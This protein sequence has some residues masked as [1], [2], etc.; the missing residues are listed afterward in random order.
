[1]RETRR[2]T[3]PATVNSSQ[4]RISVGVSFPGQASLLPISFAMIGKATPSAKRT[5]AAIADD[6]LSGLSAMTHNVLGM[7]GGPFRRIVRAHGSIRR[8]A[9]RVN[10]HEPAPCRGSAGHNNAYS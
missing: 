9:R 4:T 10:G 6:L 5:T 2:Q 7:S 1:M 3:S 8:T